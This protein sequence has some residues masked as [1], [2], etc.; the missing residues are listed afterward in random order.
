MFSAVSL[1]F[2]LSVF[3]T[4]FSP[5]ALSQQQSDFSRVISSTERERERDELLSQ[6]F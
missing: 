3:S 5:L 1:P 4:V 2:C 6:E